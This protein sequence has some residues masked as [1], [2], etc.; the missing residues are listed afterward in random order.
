MLDIVMTG[1]NGFLASY[2]IKSLL[3]ANDYYNLNTKIICIARNSRSNWP[4]ASRSSASIRR[5]R[6][7]GRLARI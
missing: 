3:A 4:R 5:S 7:A 1:G 2:V 6:G